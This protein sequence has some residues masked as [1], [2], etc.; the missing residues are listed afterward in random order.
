MVHKK[1]K[2]KTG[3][4][5]YHKGIRVLGYSFIKRKM[6][7]DGVYSNKLNVHVDNLI[8]KEKAV[9]IARLK[10]I[11]LEFYKSRN[12]YTPF[13]AYLNTEIRFEITKY[14]DKF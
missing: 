12:K 9:E 4:F 8:S 2:N 10:A 5:I 13:L 6:L 3:I 7:L 11:E 1:K 14:N